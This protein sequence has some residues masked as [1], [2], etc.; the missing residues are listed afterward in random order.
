MEQDYLKANLLEE[1]KENHF[2][3]TSESVC[4]GHP[5]KMCD[6]ILLFFIHFTIFFFSSFQ[7]AFLMLLYQ[8]IRNQ[9]WLARQLL[10]II[11]VLSLEK[12]LVKENCSMNSLCVKLL[13]IL[14]TIT[15]NKVWTTVTP[16]SLQQ[17]INKVKRFLMQLSK[18][19]SLKKL[20]QV[21]KD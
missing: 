12:S 21:I 9:K 5:D 15:L 11:S 10:R 13:K 1:L 17:S 3:F 6:V 7:I 14:A 16:Q 19:I 2:L 20:A 8:R 18:A 4:R